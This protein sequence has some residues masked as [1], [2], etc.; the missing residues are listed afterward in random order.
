MEQKAIKKEIISTIERLEGLSSIYE[1]GNKL[2]LNKIVLARRLAKIDFEQENKKREEAG[3]PPLKIL[4]HTSLKAQRRIIAVLEKKGGEASIKEIA[5]ELGRD[6]RTIRNDT[7]KMDFELINQ[8]R[9]KQK[10]SP[11]AV[12]RHS[13]TKVQSHIAKMEKEKTLPIIIVPHREKIDEPPKTQAE[14]NE[15]SKEIEPE[16]FREYPQMI[17]DEANKTENPL[18]TARQL[19]EIRKA[20]IAEGCPRA[21]A[22]LLTCRFKEPEKAL[23]S[24]KSG[25]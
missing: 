4:H 2:G 8:W 23:N 16:S 7:K 21:Q 14:K 15:E 18:E 5:Q 10:K 22:T 1:L 6:R 17:I 19:G 20:L 3:K 12:V 13:K 24:F 9:R 25:S 11:L